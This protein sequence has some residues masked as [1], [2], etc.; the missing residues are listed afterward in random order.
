MPQAAGVVGSVIVNC[1]QK[2]FK[3]GA[4]SWVKLANTPEKHLVR[5]RRRWGLLFIIQQKFNRYAEYVC[6][7]ADLVR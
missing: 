3:L 2:L 6:N 5:I 1:L 7:P 4:L